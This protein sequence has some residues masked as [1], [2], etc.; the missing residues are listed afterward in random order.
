LNKINTFSGGKVNCSVDVTVP[1]SKADKIMFQVTL[2]KKVGTSWQS[3]TSWN[4]TVSVSSSN[5][6]SFYQFDWRK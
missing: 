4:K 5:M 1:Q 6:A 3:V 2:Y